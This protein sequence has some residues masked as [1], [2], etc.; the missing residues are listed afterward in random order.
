MPHETIIHTY[1]VANN[2]LYMLYNRCDMH[3]LVYILLSNGF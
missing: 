2:L 1:M 3:A